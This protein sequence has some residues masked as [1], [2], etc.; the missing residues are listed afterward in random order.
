MKETMTQFGGRG[1]G[2]ADMAQGGIPGANDAATLEK[3]LA[4]AAAKLT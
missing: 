3:I 2:T 1:G 4:E